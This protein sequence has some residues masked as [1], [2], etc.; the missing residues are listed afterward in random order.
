MQKIQILFSKLMDFII[1]FV[2]FIW[3]TQLQSLLARVIIYTRSIFWRV[4]NSPG[5]LE[6][7][8]TFQ[9]IR[10]YHSFIQKTAKTKIW[11]RQIQLVQFRIFL[12][13][14]SFLQVFAKHQVKMYGFIDQFPPWNQKMPLVLSW[15]QNIIE[16]YGLECRVL[17]KF[18]QWRK[19]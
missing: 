14:Y 4:L 19:Y 1:F 15:Y 3:I 7:F 11:F 2:K 13:I 8:G 17:Q 18:W 9:F 16:K 12:T 6:Y 5:S 10:S